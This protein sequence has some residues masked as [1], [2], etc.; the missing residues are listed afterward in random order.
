MAL[1]GCHKI[2]LLSGEKAYVSQGNGFR[3]A[4]TH[5][6]SKLVAHLMVLAGSFKIP[7]YRT[8]AD[9]QITQRLCLHTAV[10]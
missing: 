6:T 3:I 8:F 10:L 9:R 5:F 4:I 7:F 2:S 1:T